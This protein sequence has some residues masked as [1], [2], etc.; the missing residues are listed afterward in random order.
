MKPSRLAPFLGLASFF[1][2]SPAQAIPAFARRY[3][4]ECVFCHDGFPKL[5]VVGQRFKERG[6]RL[7]KEDVFDVSRWIKSLPVTFR[8]EATRTF[9]EN[10]S[11]F[12]TGFLKG[13]SAGNL[14]TKVSYWVDDAEVFSSADNSNT[15]PDN[16]W[17]RYEVLSGNRLYAKAGRFELDLPFTNVRSP[18]L[19][20]YQIYSDNTGFETESL[21]NH[22]DGVEIGGDL[23]Q[24]IHWSASAVDGHSDVPNGQSAPFD[25]NVYLRGAK[26]WERNR[27]GLLAYAGTSTLTLGFGNEQW[28]DHFVRVGADLSVW[29]D[30]LNLYGV[31]LFG[32]NS[33]SVA[34]NEAPTG[35]GIGSSFNG[36]FV[37]ADYQP[38]D[39]VS[40]TLRLNVVNK[41]LPGESGPNLSYSSLFPGVQIFIFQH[42]KVSFEYG[43]QNQ[44]QKGI[45][46][47]QAEFAF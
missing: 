42:G 26:R 35:T 46:E 17:V 31:Y 25:L 29:F 12:N 34:T 19:F 27:V 16:A 13:I 4:V 15:K 9:V 39:F 23:P 6:F 38:K 45:G 43:F 1:L 8:G 2:P 37:Q 41:P 28:T 30:R 10:G 33:N 36:G 11:S 7:D 47:V 3:G 40:L 20:P 5:N 14:G 44:G 24:D 32:H 18:H 21:A 22:K